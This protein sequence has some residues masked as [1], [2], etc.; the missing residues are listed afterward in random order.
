MLLGYLVASV[1]KNLLEMSGFMLGL[2][3]FLVVLVLSYV[4]VNGIRHLAQ[5]LEIL[6][7]PNERSSHSRS[8]PRGGGLTIV[9]LSLLGVWLDSYAHPPSDRRFLFAYTFGA[10][11]IVIISW[12]D[13]IRSQPMWLR[14]SVHSLA[15]IVAVYGVGY[16][17]LTWIFSSH[18]LLAAVV[19]V[20]LTF[21]WIVGL[22]NAYNFMDGIDG[23][24]AGQ[25]FVASAGWAAVG[26]LTHQ[27]FL[28]I[29]GLLLAAS[30]LGFLFHNWPP[31]RIFMGD[32]GSAFLG[33]T[34][35]V[36]PLVLG[37]EPRFQNRGLVIFISGVILVWPFVFDSTFTFFRRLRFGENVF[38]A[39]R[40]H[41]YQRLV[42]L[43]Y[44]HR[45]VSLLY[46]G[47]ATVGVVMAIAGLRLGNMSLLIAVI[48]PILGFA[49]WGMV[50]RSEHK[51]GSQRASV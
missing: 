29:F 49:V 13:D 41:L 45:S 5:R 10:L 36:M 42:L 7:I 26:F 8:V 40:S 50:T 21:I 47:L 34:F 48:L 20:S 11:L 44:T 24:A 19:G 6:D 25:A 37:A 15:A 38:E 9:I 3:E 39:H 4:G 32:V 27:S 1:S 43:G 2:G 17:R 16:F 33:Y 35:A 31:A 12:L 30:S 51:A 46:V 23:I 22:T 14:L 28:L 18:P